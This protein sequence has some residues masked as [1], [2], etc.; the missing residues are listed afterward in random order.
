[1]PG[2][3]HHKPKSTSSKKKHK[4]GIQNCTKLETL[5][6]KNGLNRSVKESD[7]AAVRFL[8]FQISQ[9]SHKLNFTKTI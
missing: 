3:N 6:A 4:Y 5:I 8:L 2:V 7:V 9:R 1:M